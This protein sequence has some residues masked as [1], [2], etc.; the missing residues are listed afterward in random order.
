[1]ASEREAIV[2]SFVRVYEHNGANP[3]GRY[4]SMPRRARHGMFTRGR[5]GI[6]S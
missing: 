6:G 2:V 1:M 3:K 5:Q 4:K